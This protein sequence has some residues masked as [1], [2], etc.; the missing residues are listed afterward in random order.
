MSHTGLYLCG[1]CE[2]QYA[3]SV[4]V[5]QQVRFCS[6]VVE[7]QHCDHALS[8]DKQ[9]RVKWKQHCI[10]CCYYRGTGLGGLPVLYPLPLH[11]QF[12]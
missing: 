5:L 6:F 12:V 3:S 10:L 1:A 4:R 2:L 8:P 9:L 7:V 11:C